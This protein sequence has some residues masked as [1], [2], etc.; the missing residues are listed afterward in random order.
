MTPALLD[1]LNHP[2]RRQ[3]LRLLHERTTSRSPTEMS[4]K[5]TLG[6]TGISYHARVLSDL[7]V[8]RLSRTGQVRGSTQHFYVSRVAKIALVD[9]ILKKT[10]KEDRRLLEQRAH[11]EK[12][13]LG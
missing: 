12:A 13:R 4:Q 6:L 5:M 11:A 8:I 7:D 9:A 10:E 1:A 2:I 3:L